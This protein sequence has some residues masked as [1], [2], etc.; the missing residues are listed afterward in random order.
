MSTTRRLLAVITIILATIISTTAVV[1]A[2]APDDKTS[3]VRGVV[4]FVGDSNVTLAGGNIANVF[5]WNTPHEAYPYVPMLAPKVGASVRYPDCP[6][7]AG[8]TT[9]EFW[10]TKLG[11]IF[12]KADPDAVVLNLGINDARFAGTETTPGHYKYPKKIAWFM[13]LIPADTQVF[14]TNLPCDIEP[15]DWQ[16]GC[17]IIDHALAVADN[18]FPNLTVVNWAARASGHPE[19]MSSPGTNV[20]L[21]GIGTSAWAN[22]VIQAIDAQFL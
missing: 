8:C 10:R 5:T 12:A 2:V 22:L 20:H 17:G 21:S 1:R 6:V 14:W 13:S 9:T 16:A 15:P 4:L 3:H 11:E 7:I 18:K 19:F